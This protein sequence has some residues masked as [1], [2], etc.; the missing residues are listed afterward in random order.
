[1]FDNNYNKYDDAIKGY[2]PRFMNNI[3]FPQLIKDYGNTNFYK[4]AY[5]SCSYLS[6]FEGT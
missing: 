4:E 2:A 1:M 3:Y 5:K 6:D